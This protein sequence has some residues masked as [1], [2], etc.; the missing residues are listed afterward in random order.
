MGYA[1]IA[2][3]FGYFTLFEEDH[4]LVAVEWGHAPD[5]QQASPLL[6]EAQTQLDAYFHGH[7]QRFTLPL[8]PA[9]TAFQCRVWTALAAIPFAT[10]VTYGAIARALGTGPRAVAQAC[11]RNPLPIIIPCHRVVGANGTLG[12][13]SGGDGP[14]TK[15]S[16]LEL[17][18]VCTQSENRPQA[19]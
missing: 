8:R 5:P 15:R 19:P 1:C 3:P 2:T 4:A 9:G 16:L 11:S 18:G 6:T 13:Y 10:V 12:G 7:L 17:E 14:S